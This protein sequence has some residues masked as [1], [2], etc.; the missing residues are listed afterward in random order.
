MKPSQFRI[1]VG[2]AA[3]LI[4]LVAALEN[5]SG[6]GVMLMGPDFVAGMSQGQPAFMKEFAERSMG[7]LSEAMRSGVYRWVS[8]VMSLVGLLAACCLGLGGLALLAGQRV[9][10]RLLTVWGAYGVAAAPILTWLS[11]NYLLPQVA[12]VENVELTRLSVLAQG[13]TSLLM[14]WLLPVA[15]LILLRRPFLWRDIDKPQPKPVPL[16]TAPAASDTPLGQVPAE[17]ASGE[18]SPRPSQSPPAMREPPVLEPPDFAARHGGLRD[19]PW[20]DP[21][22]N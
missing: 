6:A 20:N 22:A 18:D 13:V 10:R 9:S 17:S 12:A 3:V 8:M 16:T 1:I 14:M 4:A 7:P 15:L 11:A 21:N 5:A 2:I 19:D